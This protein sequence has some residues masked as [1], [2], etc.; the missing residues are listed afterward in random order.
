MKLY[1]ATEQAYKNGYKQGYEDGKR[2]AAE[3]VHGRWEDDHGRYVCSC[4]HIRFTDE[5]VWIAHPDCCEPNYCPNCGAKMD[6]E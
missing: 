5:L 1:E 6:L 4:C 3:V 2:A